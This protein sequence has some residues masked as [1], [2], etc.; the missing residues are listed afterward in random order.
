MWS[1]LISFDRMMF[2]PGDRGS[3][4][5]RNAFKSPVNVGVQDDKEIVLSYTALG[6]PH[7]IPQIYLYGSILIESRLY[8]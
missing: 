2:G 5:P 7:N 3:L 1:S 8:V 6:K 4:H